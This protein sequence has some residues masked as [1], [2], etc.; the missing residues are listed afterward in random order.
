LCEYNHTCI[1][2]LLRTLT[3][4]SQKGQMGNNHSRSHAAPRQPPTAHPYAREGNKPIMDVGSRQPHCRARGLWCAR[5]LAGG[6]LATHGA[7][8]GIWSMDATRGTTL[9]S[10]GEEARQ[11]HVRPRPARRPLRHWRAAHGR[12]LASGSRDV[13]PARWGT[14]GLPAISPSQFSGLSV[15]RWSSAWKLGCCC[16]YY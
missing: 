3:E 13:V 4:E 15:Q 5:L 8:S 9:Q 6:K 10:E 1:R 16:R 14:A 7:A 2:V 11:W 12:S